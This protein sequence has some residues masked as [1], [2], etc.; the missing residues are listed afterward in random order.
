MGTTGKIKWE[1]NKISYRQALICI[2]FYIDNYNVGN[3][4]ANIL[5]NLFSKRDHSAVNVWCIKKGSDYDRLE[6]LIKDNSGMLC[7]FKRVVEDELIRLSGHKN[8]NIP[9]D[10]HEEYLKEAIKVTRMPYRFVCNSANREPN[11]RYSLDLELYNW[12]FNRV[13]LNRD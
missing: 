5:L 6:N 11:P 9:D 12:Y 1:K 13:F 7:L 8:L 10:L 3:Y 4:Q 2:L